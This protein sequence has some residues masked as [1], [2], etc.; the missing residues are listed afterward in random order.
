MK[1]S[2]QVA[3]LCTVGAAAFAVLPGC[4]NR[5]TTDTTSAAMPASATMDRAMVA[6]RDTEWYSSPDVAHAEKGRLAANSKVFF[7]NTAAAGE[8]Q[9]ARTADGKV[10]YV[11]AADFTPAPRQ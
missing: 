6:V 4:Q 2:L 3:L 5:G 9:S 8:L 1:R 11:R 10:V 7:D